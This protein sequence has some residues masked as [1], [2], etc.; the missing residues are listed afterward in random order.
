MNVKRKEHQ[1]LRKFE[2]AINNITVQFCTEDQHSYSWFFP[3]YAEGGIHERKVTEMLIKT[4]KGAK[5]FV[6]V[7]TYLGWYTC[8]ASKH[9]P[10]GK[11]YGFEMDELNYALLQK[12]LSINACK[13]VKAFNVAVSD[14]YGTLSYRREENLPSPILRLDAGRTD[15]SSSRLVF[16]AAVTLDGFFRSKS[17]KPDVIKIDVE[18]AEMNVL[19]G[20]TQLIKAHHPLLFLE[21]HPLHLLGYN[22]SV[23]DILMFLVK[24]QYKVFEIE[25]LR[26][27]DSSRKLNELSPESVLVENS[28]VY[29]VLIK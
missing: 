24:N 21:V 20:M 6:D 13:N 14:A 15:N 9:M 3:R 8:L 1:R 19:R 29:A 11:V 12:N 23:F 25:N 4:L 27:Q 16:V 28:M 22:S 10:Q 17:I 5:C 18:G 2:L 7:G 26:S